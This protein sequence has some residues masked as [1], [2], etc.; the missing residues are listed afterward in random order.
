MKF[1]FKAFDKVDRGKLLEDLKVI[2][3]A[4]ELHI[5]SVLVKDVKLRVRMGNTLGRL[6]TTNIGVPQGDYLSPVLFTLYL[7]T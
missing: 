3:N 2:L 5:I 4:D 6:F 7:L 1:Q